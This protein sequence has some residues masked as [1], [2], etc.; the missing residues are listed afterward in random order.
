MKR[1]IA[2]GTL[3]I[4]IFV[5][6]V[7]SLLANE[8]VPF[9]GLQVSSENLEKIKANRS[10]TD[11]DLL[12]KISF[13]NSP[14][15]YDELTAS[16]F[17]SVSPEQSDADPAVTYK[18]TAKNLKLAVSG[19]IHP[20][21]TIPMIVYSEKEYREYRL[22]ITPLPLIRIECDEDDFPPFVEGG[23]SPYAERMDFRIRFTMIDNRPSVLRKIIRSDGRF[24]VRGSGSATY[25]KTGFRLTLFEKA[26]GKELHENRTPLLGLRADGDWLLYSGYNDQE[27]IRN[28][29]SSNL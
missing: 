2:V 8:K 29:F 15:F 17:C 28:V 13:D 16:W 1:L 19:E 25:E 21:N 4:S 26:G 20:G 24:H 23:F 14:L 6:C 18:G 27:K 22:A 12:K 3:C 5:F 11:L 7:L 9:S 10:K